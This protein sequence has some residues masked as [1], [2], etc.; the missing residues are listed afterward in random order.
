M[1]FTRW[2]LSCEQCEEV[3]AVE[4]SQDL[5]KQAE[6]GDQAAVLRSLEPKKR[7][8]IVAFYTQH[9]GHGEGCFPVLLSPI[10]N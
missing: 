2:G 4:V 3:C 6:A 1:I 8:E 9:D 10:E 7:L 5:V